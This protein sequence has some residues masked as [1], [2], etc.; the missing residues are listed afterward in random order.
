MTEREREV[1]LWGQKE[2]R[3]RECNGEQHIVDNDFWKSNHFLK[4]L[5][6]LF[7]WNFE[8]FEN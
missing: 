7:F 3:G 8:R 6:I 4:V 1:E 2:K 5:M